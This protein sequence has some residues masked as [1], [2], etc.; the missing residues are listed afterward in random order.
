M[1]IVEDARLAEIFRQMGS[2]CQNEPYAASVGPSPVDPLKNG[3]ST[4]AIHS[5]PGLHRA[6][7]MGVDAV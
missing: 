4:A 2:T 3:I 7:R 5:M 6:Y 1:L